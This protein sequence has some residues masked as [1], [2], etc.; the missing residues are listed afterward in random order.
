MSDY[1]SDWDSRRRNVYKRD[2]YECQNCGKKGAHRGDAELHAHHIV[3]ISKGGSH[4]KSNLK[5][6]CRRCHSKIHPHLEDDDNATRRGQEGMPHTWSGP[7]WDSSKGISQAKQQDSETSGSSYSRSIST[8][9]SSTDTKSKHSDKVDDTQDRDA[10]K[11]PLKNISSSKSIV[12][13]EHLEPTGTIS[14]NSQSKSAGTYSVDSKKDSSD[15][16]TDSQQKDSETIGGESAIAALLGILAN[17]FIG[18]VFVA[19]SPPSSGI[20]I[21]IFLLLVIIF[22]IPQLYLVARFGSKI[23]V[24]LLIVPGIFAIIT[25]YILSYV[26]SNKD[27]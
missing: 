12:Y 25:D 16:V 27:E 17:S 10:Q 20:T 7:E 21:Q 18:A 13:N 8:G 4:K 11:E 5:T 26:K 22:T 2:N 3:P 6:L 24:F 15:V 1:P 9:E 23:P 14:E 19:I